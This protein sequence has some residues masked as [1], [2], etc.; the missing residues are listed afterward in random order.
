MDFDDAFFD[1]LGLAFFF[2]AAMF[3]GGTKAAQGLTILTKQPKEVML[4]KEGTKPK[5]D[6]II[7]GIQKC[8]GFRKM[9]GIEKCWGYGRV[10][11]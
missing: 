6:A 1:F 2:V 11:G 8:C 4:A 7:G 5:E 10:R 9:G 3:N